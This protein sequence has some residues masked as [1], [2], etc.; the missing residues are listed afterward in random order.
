MIDKQKRK[1]LTLVG[2]AAIASAAPALTF[3]TTAGSDRKLSAKQCTAATGH[4]QCME[5]RLELN[6]AQQT[7]LTISNDSD[8][9]AIVRHVYPGIVHTGT[10]TFDINAAFANG[11]REIEAG[12]SITVVIQ[13]TQ[14]ITPKETEFPRHKYSR[15]PQQIARLSGVDEKGV[16]VNSTRSFYS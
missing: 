3:A 15:L 12:Q 7:L 9:R 16:I 10:R 6:V 4:N 8:T 14:S 1:T 5:L 13:P 2:T 11:S